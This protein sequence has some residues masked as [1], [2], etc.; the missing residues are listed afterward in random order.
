MCRGTR[1]RPAGRRFGLPAPAWLVRI[2]APL[3]MK[4]DPE[5]ALCG[6]YCVSRRLREEGFSFEFEEIGAGLA[7][8]LRPARWAAD[9]HSR[10]FSSHSCANLGR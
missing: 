8:L 9:E 10:R 3:V 4:T 5:L 7:D 2:G 1:G 6:R